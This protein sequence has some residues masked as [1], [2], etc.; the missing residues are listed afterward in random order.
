MLYKLLPITEALANKSDT[1]IKNGQGSS[2]E[3]KCGSQVTN[4]VY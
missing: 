2:F 4:V 1:V 3:K